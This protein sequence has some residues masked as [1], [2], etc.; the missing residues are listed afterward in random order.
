MYPLVLLAILIGA[1]F[2]GL[3][4]KKRDGNRLDIAQYAAVHGLIAG[5]LAL[6]LMVILLRYMVA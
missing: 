5:V 6:I 2:G 3:R 1:I 4:A